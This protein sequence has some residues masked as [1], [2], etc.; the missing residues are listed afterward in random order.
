MKARIMFKKIFLIAIIL[1]IAV[2]WL[3]GIFFVSFSPFSLTISKPEKDFLKR[4]VAK[5]KG[6]IYRE[7][8][9]H[10]PAGDVFP[11]QLDDKV[12]QEIKEKIN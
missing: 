9:Q 5:A 1:T 11:D 6:I 3:G 4:A 2:A 8:A 7:A 10:N 12:K